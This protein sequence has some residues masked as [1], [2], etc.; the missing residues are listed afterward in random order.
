MSSNYSATPSASNPSA[1]YGLYPSWLLNPIGSDY[2]AEFGYT[3]TNQISQV[4]R[5]KIVDSIPKQWGA[6]KMF[7][8]KEP[9][10]KGNKEYTWV[11]KL[12]QRPVLYASAGVAGS[13]AQSIIL[14]AGGTGHVVQNDLVTYPNNTQGVVTSVTTSTNTINLAPL[15][16]APDLPTVSTNDRFTITAAPISDGQNSFMHY[17]R[18][19]T[20]E[21]T[22]WMFRGQRN[23]RWDTV[24]A[25]VWKNQ[26][27]TDYF[28]RD[29]ADLMQECYRDMFIVYMN[30]TK[31][32][33]DITVQ[34]DAALTAGTF[35]ARM[36]D[37]LYPFMQ[38]YGAMH[39]TSSP[40]TLEAD[41]KSLAFATN[42]ESVG[43]TR[44]IL[45][46]DRALHMLSTIWKDP[47]RYTANDTMSSL[48]L[49]EYTFGTMKFVPIVTPQFE[50]GTGMFPET[51]AS[52]LIVLNPDNISPTCITGFQPITAGNTGSQSKAMGGYN[53]YIDYF[54]EYWVGFQM[55]TVGSSFWIDMINI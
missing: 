3:E 6:L 36:G 51:F 15:N 22:N 26:G 4:I 5:Q 20:I 7:L 1:T 28:E 33:M 41:F 49:T 35:K 39:A 46:T 21:Y 18:S 53:D 13:S 40:A 52:K 2:A 38:K 29:A 37:G 11:E 54:C 43:A 31:G 25:Q 9:E 17:D 42:H 12:W 30:G 48:D 55:H 45:G 27:T 16:G 24:T 47:V 50:T 34:G 44:F 8:G 23:K 14:T 32:E 10:Y 19:T